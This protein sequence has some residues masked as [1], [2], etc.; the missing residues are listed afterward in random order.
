MSWWWRVAAPASL[1]IACSA[2]SR[3]EAAPARSIVADIVVAIDNR[4]SRQ[5][6][7]YLRADTAEYL[8]GAVAHNSSHAF[9][10]P[11]GAGDS[12]IALWL[13]ARDPE[14]GSAAQS[15]PF[16]LSSGHRVSWTLDG[17]RTGAVTMR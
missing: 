16:R 8:L 14:P 4:T 6:V 13:E 12:T 10:L 3:R 9:S 15:H 11:S 2:D 5:A 7:I 1:V 17:T